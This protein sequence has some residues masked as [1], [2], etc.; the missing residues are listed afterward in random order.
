MLFNLIVCCDNRH[1]IGRQNTIPWRFT[2]DI[3]NFKKITKGNITND[4]NELIEN[5]RNIVIMGNN[6]YKSILDNYRPLKHRI[7]IV[8]SKSQPPT[9]KHNLENYNYII[10][11]PVYFNN[12][13]FLLIY[14][15]AISSFTNECFI[16][17][18][19]Q[20]YN[21]FLDLKLVNKIYLTKIND[22]SYG[23]DVIFN[24]DKYKKYFQLSENLY[25]KDIDKRSGLL[26]SLL[27]S[28]YDYQNKEENNFIKTVYK[29]LNKGV[30][31]L[32]RSKVGTISIFGK[33]F[34]YNIRNYR[35]P[36]FTHRKLFLRG[37]IEEL[38]FFISGNTNTKILEKKGVNIWKGHTSREYLDSRG[39]NHLK[40]GDMGLGYSHQLRNWGGGD[41]NKGIDQLEYV[42][43]EIKNNPTS[44]RI[45]FSYWNPSD[46]DKTALPPCHLLYN[47]HVNVITNELSCSFYQ[48]SNDFAL[49][50]NFNVCSAAILVF[51][52]CKICNL[53][54][55]KIIHNI[56]NIHIYS[57]QIDIVK[58][59][60]KNKPYNAPLLF[61]DDPD[62]EIKKIE[63]FKYEHFKLLFYKS[64]KKYNI[65]MSV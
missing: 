23:C 54:P 24:F 45:L 49:A 53:K 44:R 31:N 12:I 61:I 15:N 50:C 59:F 11:N 22:V 38:L 3:I 56:G 40:E 36:L 10:S 43:N 65:P 64:H 8:I 29:I 16:I 35:L 2:K 5:K 51:M 47:F 27:Y 41:I 6:T 28:V 4:S 14:I 37:I 62:N 42:I 33:S 63:D 7:N 17:G 18:G 39:L 9:E 34:T 48:R 46:L 30:Y 52:L 60:I 26:K 55:G 1:G 32:D 19:S 25:Y 21:M 13:Q 20:I 57:N 58:E